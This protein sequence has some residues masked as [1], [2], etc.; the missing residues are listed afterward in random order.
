MA[1]NRGTC[2]LLISYFKFYFTHM[3]FPRLAEDKSANIFFYL[4]KGIC[5]RWCDQLFCIK[6]FFFGNMYEDKYP[7]SNKYL[8][9]S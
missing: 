9:A 5:R 1:H 3:N 2:L 6:K 8:V 4:Y 7:R